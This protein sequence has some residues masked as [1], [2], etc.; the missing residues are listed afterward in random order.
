VEDSVFAD[1]D[2]RCGTV[3]RGVCDEDVATV[4]A[5]QLKVSPGQ[6]RF[7]YW[8]TLDSHLPVLETAPRSSDFACG[9]DIN[10][11]RS[12]DLCTL[13]RTVFRLHTTVAAIALDPDLPPTMFVIVGDHAPPFVAPSKRELFSRDRVPYVV[14]RPV[15]RDNW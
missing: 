14:L 6:R 5:D 7:V 3:F 4:F 2:R 10:A 15:S 8:L 11:R 9:S 12:K 13:M 1:F